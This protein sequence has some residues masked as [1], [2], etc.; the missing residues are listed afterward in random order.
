[1]RDED[2]CESQDSPSPIAPAVLLEEAGS[3]NTP[4]ENVD[5]GVYVLARMKIPKDTWTSMADGVN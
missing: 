2:Y 3:R 1:M 4:M 5:R